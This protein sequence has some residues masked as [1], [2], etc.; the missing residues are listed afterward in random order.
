MYRLGWEQFVPFVVTVL[1]IVFSDLL[2]G[3]GIGMAVAILII[4]RRSY[5]NSHFL[6]LKESEVDG[7]NDLHLELSE[8]VTFLNKGAILRELDGIPNGTR[9]TIDMRR[10]VAMDYDVLEII[11]NFESTAHERGIQVKKY[12]PQASAR[13]NSAD[14]LEGVPQTP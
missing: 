2:T 7:Q 11:E 9:V 8:E 1:G 13:N 4:L 14:S 6:H 10:C 12:H 5:L 3:I